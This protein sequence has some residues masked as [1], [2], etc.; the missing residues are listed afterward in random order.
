M[1]IFTL[2][3]Y[4]SGRTGL[5]KKYY[6]YYYYFACNLALKLCKINVYAGVHDSFWTHACDV[7]NMSQIL[8]EKFV[9]LYDMPILEN[10][11]SCSIMRNL[12][13][14]VGIRGQKLF[15]NILLS[16]M[17]VPGG[18]LIIVLCCGKVREFLNLKLKLSEEK[19]K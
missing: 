7:E 19:I 15:L 10:V 9:E 12:G 5:L 17:K 4:F 13:L 11:S 8:R 3:F 2:K 6:F 18:H 16:N 14:V 1:N